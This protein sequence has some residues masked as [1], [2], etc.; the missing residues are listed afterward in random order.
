LRKINLIIKPEVLRSVD[1]VKQTSLD[2]VGI[3]HDDT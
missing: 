3:G 2:D 1:K